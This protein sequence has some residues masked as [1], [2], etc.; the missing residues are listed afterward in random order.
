MSL[1][2]PA[3]AKLNLNLNIIGQRSDGYHLLQSLFQLVDACDYVHIKPAKD[4]SFS[5][6][7]PDLNGDDNLVVKAAKLLQQH[8]GCTLGAEIFLD[9]QLPFGG[10]LGS[11]SSDAATTLLGLNALWNC[12]LDNNTLAQLGLSLGADVPIFIKG[13]SAWVEGIG[14]QITP[15]QIPQ[16]YYV[17]VAPNCHVSTVKIFT[18]ERL[19]RNSSIIKVRLALE[20]QAHNDCEAL[21]RELYPQV[22]SA[23]NWL[24]QFATARLTGTGGC[25]FAQFDSLEDARAIVSMLPT[26]LSGIVCR[27]CNTSPLFKAI[28]E[29]TTGV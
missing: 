13:H 10:G 27:G 29:Q 23:L 16:K 1:V 8:T 20:G 9:K 15:V 5:C 6:N 7:H 3:P 24:D 18:H 2:L 11:G 12:R 25:V 4:I 22:D 19:T 26:N 28:E 21:V 14:E 17:V